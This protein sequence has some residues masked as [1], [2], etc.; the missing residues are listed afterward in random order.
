MQIPGIYYII[1]KYSSFLYNKSNTLL[2]NYLT[3]TALGYE[4][5]QDSNRENGGEREGNQVVGLKQTERPGTLST[6]Y[7]HLK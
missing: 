2:F 5:H 1:N 6:I 3:F 7:P 4:S